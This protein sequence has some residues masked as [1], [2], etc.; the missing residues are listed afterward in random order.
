MTSLSLAL[1]QVTDMARDNMILLTREGQRLDREDDSLDRV[2]SL[3]DQPDLYL[4]SVTPCSYNKVINIP[5]LVK[6]ALTNTKRSL[7]AGIVRGSPN[8]P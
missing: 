7:Q 5:D 4:Y 8:Y 1:A 2:S 3:P 6:L